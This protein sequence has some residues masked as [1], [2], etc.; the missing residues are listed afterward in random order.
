MGARHNDSGFYAT[1]QNQMDLAGHN[2]QPCAVMTTLLT[3]IVEK[4]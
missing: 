3:R 2:Q 4:E 1:D